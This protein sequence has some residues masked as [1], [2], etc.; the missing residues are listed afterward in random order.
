MFDRCRTL[1]RKGFMSTLSYGS[2]SD[3]CVGS[4]GMYMSCLFPVFLSTET[5]TDNAWFLFLTMHWALVCVFS[6]GCM[7]VPLFADRRDLTGDQL[8]PRLA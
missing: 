3:F 5:L 7:M 8:F 6:I 1:V 4:D 2:L